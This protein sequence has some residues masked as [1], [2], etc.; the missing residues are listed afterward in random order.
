MLSVDGLNAWYGRAQAL[1]N[2]NLS[3]GE[4]ELVVM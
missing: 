1:I 2:V 4:G 3:V